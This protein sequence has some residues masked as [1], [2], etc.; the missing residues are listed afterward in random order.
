M[1]LSGNLTLSARRHTDKS[2]ARAEILAAVKA[3]KGNLTEAARRLGITK[4]TLSRW[5]A[6][7]RSLAA[8]CKAARKET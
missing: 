6:S 3:A 2:K 8:A 4:R 7:D 5:L 1:A